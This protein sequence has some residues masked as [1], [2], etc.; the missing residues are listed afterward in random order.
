MPLRK[1][2][3]VPDTHVPYHDEQ[4]F[5]LLLK[6]GRVFEPDTVVLLGDFADFYSVSSHDKDPRRAS[7][8]EY[9]VGI[10]KEKLAELKKLGASRHV[11]ICGNHEE[12]LERYLMQ[13][14]PALFGTVKI[15]DVLGLRNEWEFVP[16]K[17]SFKL[18]KLNL[19]HDTGTAGQNAHRQSMD[20]YQGSAAIGHTHRMEFSVRG[21]ASGSPQVGAMFGWLGDFDKVDYMHQIKAKRD[22]VHGFGL[23]HME[24]TGVI[25]ITPVPMVNG[26][27]VVCGK[28]VQ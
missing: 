15:P 20:A 28:L 12:R 7:D 14:A 19:T 18:G 24:D 9:E 22:W 5:K 4:A 25:H 11:Y 13:K 16:Y 21:K 6:A 8:L 2:L 10:V 26:K 3:F 17:R 1:V 23:G 27:V